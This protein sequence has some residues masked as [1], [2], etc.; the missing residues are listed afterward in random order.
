ML[1]LRVPHCLMRTMSTAVTFPVT[2]PR[3][4]TDFTIKSALIL[5]FRPT[6]SV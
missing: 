5:A 1:P 6:V 2:R 4:S 3:M